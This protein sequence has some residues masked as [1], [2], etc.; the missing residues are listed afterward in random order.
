M[1]I[2]ELVPGR[3]IKL[4][5]LGTAVSNTFYLVTVR[6]IMTGEGEFIT[7]ITGKAAKMEDAMASSLGGAGGLTSGLD[8]AMGAIGSA[9]SLLDDV[10]DLSGFF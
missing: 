9:S 6:H 5:G 10:P 2:P 8:S 4:K 1:G 3:F 7:K